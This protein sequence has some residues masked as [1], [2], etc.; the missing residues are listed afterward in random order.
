MSTRTGKQCRERYFNHLQPNVKKGGWTKEEDMLILDLQVKM[1][2][3]WSSMSKLLPGRTDN[4]IKNRY[5]AM[6][7]AKLV[8][9]GQPVSSYR[10]RAMSYSSDVTVG[11]TM[12]NKSSIKSESLKSEN[13]SDYDKEI[14][15]MIHVYEEV[16]NQTLESLSSNS[17]DF[18]GQFFEDNEF[19]TNDV[20]EQVQSS[21]TDV[22]ADLKDCYDWLCSIDTQEVNHHTQNR[23][24]YAVYLN[25][26]STANSVCSSD[27]WTTDDCNSIN[28]DYTHT[29]RKSFDFDASLQSTTNDYC[30]KRMRL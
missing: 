23:E 18:M 26:C 3:Q 15:Q 2:N 9:A 6:M 16:Q 7:K 1:G 19:T 30:N 11:S 13:N 5:H 22:F 29:K 27:N 12:S 20:Q 10:S 28:S 21:S 8:Q 14:Y 4:A 24:N 17:W 25:D